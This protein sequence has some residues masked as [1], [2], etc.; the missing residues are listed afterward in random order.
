MDSLIRTLGLSP[1]WGFQPPYP[2][3]SSSSDLPVNLTSLPI[4][5]PSPP[6]SPLASFPPLHKPRPS[7]LGPPARSPFSLLLFSAGTHP[8]HLL[9]PE[10]CV[11]FSSSCSWEGPSSSIPAKD[12]P[13]CH[14]PCSL[15]PFYFFHGIL[16]IYLFILLLPA[17]RP[18]PPPQLWCELHVCTTH[19]IS[20]A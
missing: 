13:F 9:I 20:R 4:T 1:R 6:C 3:G 2:A 8:S 16:V 5:L 19:S 11:L 12:P 18:R 10:G 15:P 7:Q 17:T 14:T